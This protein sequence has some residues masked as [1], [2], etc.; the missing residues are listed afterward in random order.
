MSSRHPLALVAAAA[1]LLAALPLSTVFASF[2]WLFVTAVAIAIMVGTAIAARSLRWPVPAQV[3]AM[4]GALLLF[5]AWRFPS[6]EELARLIPT[7]ATFRHFG[8]LLADSTV[9]I[10]DESVPVSDS[11][12]LLLLTVAGVGLVAIIVDFLAVGLRRPALAGLPMLAIYS[13]PVAVLPDGLSVL[14]F[15][16]ATCGCWSATASNGPAS[17]AGASPATGA[18]WTCGSP[19]RWPRPAAG[20]PRSAS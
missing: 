14:P 15:G 2:T 11:E 6:G 16:P 18:T 17:T 4:A 8:Q 13:V 9:R 7:G 20:W 12:G 5:L 3:L 19:P 10:R 1:T